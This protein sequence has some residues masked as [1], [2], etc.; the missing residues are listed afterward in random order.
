MHIL[1]V[2]HYFPPLTTVAAYRPS[3]WARYWSEAGHDIT[4]LT[5]LKGTLDGALVT[6]GPADHAYRVIELPYLPGPT[7]ARSIPRIRAHDTPGPAHQGPIALLKQVQ[8]QLRRRVIGPLFDPRRLWVG[9]ALR[10]AARLHRNRRFDAVVSTY[11]PPACHLIASRLKRNERIPWVADY[12]D[13]WGDHLYPGKWPFSWISRR[14]EERAVSCADRITTTSDAWRAVLAER[15]A[16]PSATIENG[17]D[18][19]AAREMAESPHRSD[20]R[21]RVL[22]TGTLYRGDRDPTPLFAAAAR[23]KASHPGL[24][25]RLELAFAGDLEGLRALSERFGL[26]S[27]VTILPPVPLAVSMAL[28]RDADLLLFLDWARE[29]EGWLTAKLFEYIHSGTPILALGASP[30]LTASRTIQEMRAGVALGN[31]VGRIE[32]TLTFLLQGGSLAYSPDAA[33]LAHYS[34]EALARRMLALVEEVVR[35]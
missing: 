21:Y 28:Q 24:A 4:V 23:L 17:Y 10:E 26:E 13:L 27:M 19:D 8:R 9:P 6:S 11:G 2:S 16:I 35:G 31:D 14:L 7:S 29:T 20:D 3:S 22:Y 30:E 15:F 1:I 18:Q 25:A 32:E 5:T 12:R 33:T 34:R